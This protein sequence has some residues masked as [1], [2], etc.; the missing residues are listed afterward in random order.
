MFNRTLNLYILFGSF[1]PFVLLRLAKANT[2]SQRMIHLLHILFRQSSY[3][4][5]QTDMVDGPD[6]L[7]QYNG[8]LFQA[9]MVR[10]DWDMGWQRMLVL[11]AGYGRYNY[12]WAE[13]VPHVIL[14]HQHWSYAALFAAGYR[15]QVCII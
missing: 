5:P 4:L 7:Q 2:D 6:L 13:P 8:V 1:C 11:P 10:T 12:S 15:C 3:V 9:A 14:D